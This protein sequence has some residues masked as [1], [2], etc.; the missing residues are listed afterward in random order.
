MME[1][2]MGEALYARERNACCECRNG[3]PVCAAAAFPVV[4][5]SDSM[6]VLLLLSIYLVG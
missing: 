1:G 3:L 6:P 5:P 4:P 2:L